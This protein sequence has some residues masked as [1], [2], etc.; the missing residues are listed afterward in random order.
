MQTFYA[1]RQTDRQT[2]SK[3]CFT[4]VIYE[5]NNYEDFQ[6]YIIKP[7]QN[8]VEIC[9]KLYI[10]IS[11]QNFMYSDMHLFQGGGFISLIQIHSKCYN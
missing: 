3:L 8:P 4:Q 2:D 9:K 5:Y 1:N 7:N 6:I 11:I 10:N